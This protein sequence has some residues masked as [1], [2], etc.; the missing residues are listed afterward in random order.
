MCVCV[1]PEA[2]R[3]EWRNCVTIREANTPLLWLE[4]GKGLAEGAKGL[5]WIS[6]L[7]MEDGIVQ[8]AGSGSPAPNSALNGGG[9]FKVL[10][11]A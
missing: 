2:E 7:T 3:G 6:P 9:V 5:S 4:S 8:N 10:S 1:E 11:V